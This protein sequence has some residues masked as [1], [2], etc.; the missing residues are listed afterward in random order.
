M[1]ISVS[2]CPARYYHLLEIELQ[3]G[4]FEVTFTV[5]NTLRWGPE[6][7]YQ[8]VP[9]VVWGITAALYPLASLCIS[10]WGPRFREQNGSED[11]PREAAPWAASRV[12]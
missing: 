2:F 1:N 9:N 8:R 4:M 6:I 5:W 11:Q 12:H 10:W 7:I 3:I